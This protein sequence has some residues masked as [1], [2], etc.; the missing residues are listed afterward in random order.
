MKLVTAF[1]KPI[2]LDDVKA[3]LTATGASGMTVQDVGTGQC[4][5][6]P[7]RVRPEPGVLV[8]NL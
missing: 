4:H 3:A 7:S 2:K 5:E 8:T 1:I 6:A